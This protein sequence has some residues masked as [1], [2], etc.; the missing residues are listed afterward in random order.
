ML[1]RVAARYNV[2]AVVVVAICLLLAVLVAADVQVLFEVLLF[3]DD[4]VVCIPA[5][6]LDGIRG[7]GHACKHI[8]ADAV[9]HRLIIA[10]AV[11]RHGVLGA[12]AKSGGLVA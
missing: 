8:L 6:A 10:A 11:V 3:V 12:T 2:I 9:V 4:V 7:E 1:C 5:I